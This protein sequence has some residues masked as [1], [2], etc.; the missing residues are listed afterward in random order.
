MQL[1]VGKQ[2][3]IVK[4][5]AAL[6][7]WKS[8]GNYSWGGTSSGALWVGEIIEYVGSPMGIGSDNVHEDTFVLVEPNHEVVARRGFKGAF[9]RNFYGG[10]DKSFFEE[11]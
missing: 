6:T 10:A 5:G 3:K 2:Y 11:F 7:G 9:S 1:E 4:G 8:L